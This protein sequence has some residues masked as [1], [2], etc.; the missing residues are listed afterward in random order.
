MSWLSSFC[1][2]A[3]SPKDAGASARGEESAQ[4]GLEN[5]LVL[6]KL[7]K[8]SRW[9]SSPKMC[10]GTWSSMAAP[11]GNGVPCPSGFVQLPKSGRIYKVPSMSSD[12]IWL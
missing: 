11:T 7:G 3:A 8:G 5:S 10:C 12:E 9:A 4:L 2:S 1:F 6:S